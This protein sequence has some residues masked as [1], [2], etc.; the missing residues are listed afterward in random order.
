MTKIPREQTTN[1]SD[2]D[3]PKFVFDHES[4]QAARAQSPQLEAAM[5]AFWAAFHKDD[6]RLWMCVKAAV[7]ATHV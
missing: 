1:M 7:E 3:E 5:N 4:E 6:A 2:I